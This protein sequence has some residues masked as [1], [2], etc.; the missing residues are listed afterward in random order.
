MK[1]F[2][3]LLLNCGKCRKPASNQGFSK[4]RGSSFK[5]KRPT[6]SRNKDQVKT[7]TEARFQK[8]RGRGTF[9]RPLFCPSYARRRE[10]DSNPSGDMAASH[11]QPPAG[12][13]YAAEPTLFPALLP[14]IETHPAPVRGGPPSYRQPA[15]PPSEQQKS[16]LAVTKPRKTACIL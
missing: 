1:Y 15:P 4:A 2:F 16:G 9:P 14:P 3:R 10:S 8:A 7:R 11:H 13:C 5:Q 6:F 12:D